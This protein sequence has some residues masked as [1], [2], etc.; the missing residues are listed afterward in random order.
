MS[1]EVSSTARPFRS[2]QIFCEAAFSKTFPSLHVSY[3]WYQCVWTLPTLFPFFRLFI[4]LSFLRMP[5]LPSYLLLRPLS[6]SSTMVLSRLVASVASPRFSWFRDSSI[7]PNNLFVINQFSDALWVQYMPYLL[8]S[9]KEAIFEIAGVNL[10]S[11]Y[12]VCT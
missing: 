1:C 11:F 8:F 4:M 5:R 12:S 7:I 6:K 2:L 10:I 3:Q 9:A